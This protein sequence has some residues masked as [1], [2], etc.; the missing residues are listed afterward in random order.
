MDGGVQPPSIFLLKLVSEV[1]LLICASYYF[2]KINFSKF[3]YIILQHYITIVLVVS[4]SGRV[5]LRPRIDNN[6]VI[7]ID[8]EVIG[9]Q[10]AANTFV[11]TVQNPDG[12]FSSFH[13]GNGPASAIVSLSGV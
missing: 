10:P 11:W 7:T 4:S 12:R 6:G 9:G 3:H 13:A 1:R 2:F 5:S 8:A